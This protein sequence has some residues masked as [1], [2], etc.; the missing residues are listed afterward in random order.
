MQA[1]KVKEIKSYVAHEIYRIGKKA[2]QLHDELQKLK[3]LKF[4]FQENLDQEIVL[5]K[6]LVTEEDN[7]SEVKRKQGLSSSN[8]KSSGG[9]KSEPALAPL[10]KLSSKPTLKEID[11]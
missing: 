10:A 7:K 1:E 5:N 11:I 6:Q 8:D 2:D 4:A 9:N 3:K